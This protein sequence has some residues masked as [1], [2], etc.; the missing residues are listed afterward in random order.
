MWRDKYIAVDWGTTNRRAWLVDVHGEVVAD[1]DDHLGLMSLPK[2]GFDKEA[3]EIRHKLGDYPM[4]LAGMVG[5][6]RGWREVPYV[7]VPADVTSLAAGISWIDTHTGIIPGVC[8]TDDHPDVMRGEEVQALGALAD[9]SAAPDAFICH[10]G[11]HAKWIR[12]EN[13]KVTHFRTMMTGEIFA[14]LREHSILGAQLVGDVS[15]GATFR[16]GL[17]EAH[18]DASLLS[19]LFSIRVR[20]VLN[21]PP[22]PD[23]SFASGLLI[24]FDVQASLSNARAGEKITVIGRSDLC[25]LYASA[26][27][28]AGF[29]YDIIDG[30]QAF[31][32][33]IRSITHI[34]EP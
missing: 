1:F 30:E 8:Q 10:P 17:R 21:L 27:K 23:A 3:A 11:T 5:S 29:D 9:G 19:S 14:L 32:A 13:G 12:L 18:N 2:G 33:G 15:D 4:L 16:A 34:L 6:D 26:I 28:L 25:C 22:L 31:L 20:K 7:A 24:G